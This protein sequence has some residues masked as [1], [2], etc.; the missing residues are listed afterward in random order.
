[1]SALWQWAVVFLLC[2]IAQYQ[3]F[4][5]K[6]AKQADGQSTALLGVDGAVLALISIVSFFGLA[7]TAWQAVT[8]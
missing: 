7:I 4:A 1:M 5:T 3:W 2:D 6:R 8:R